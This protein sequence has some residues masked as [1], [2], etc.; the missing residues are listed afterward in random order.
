LRD[1]DIENKP[2][3]LAK[4]GVLDIIHVTQTGFFAIALTSELR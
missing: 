1:Q 3:F 4:I 2:V